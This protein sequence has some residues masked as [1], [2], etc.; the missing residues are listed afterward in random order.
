MKSKKLLLI[1]NNIVGPLGQVIAENTGI[2]IENKFLKY[3]GQTFNVNEI[4]KE[5][6]RWLS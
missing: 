2:L 5:V 3:D 1:E 4:V 6:K